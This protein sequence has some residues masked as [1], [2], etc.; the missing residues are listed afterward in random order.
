MVS[1]QMPTWHEQETFDPRPAELPHWPVIAVVGGARTAG[2]Q[3][4]LSERVLNVRADDCLWRFASG[5][6][7]GGDF[8]SLVRGRVTYG[9]RRPQL[10]AEGSPPGAAGRQLRKAGPGCHPGMQ[11]DRQV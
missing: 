1:P 11:T 10:L 5:L 9:R 2:S 7:V 6:I 4:V 3:I 8:A